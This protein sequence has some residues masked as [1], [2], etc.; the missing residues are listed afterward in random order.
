MEL[1]YSVAAEKS[2]SCGLGA[3]L[4]APHANETWPSSKTIM[5][6]CRAT[7]IALT[8][9]GKQSHL[10]TVTSL[11]GHSSWDKQLDATQKQQPAGLKRDCTTL[12]AHTVGI[13]QSCH[14]VRI[15]GHSI[16]NHP[17][18]QPITSN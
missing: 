15:V 16:G 18:S 2:N 13:I 7:L 3:W 11:A 10:I 5:R 6:S 12:A 9:R 14:S 17:S 8:C 4:M 1:V